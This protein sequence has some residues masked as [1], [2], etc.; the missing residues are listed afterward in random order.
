M[1]FKT[2]NGKEKL[3]KNA[4]KYLINWRTKT[5]SK[6]QDEVKKFLKVGVDTICCKRYGVCGEPFSKDITF[7]ENVSGKTQRWGC[8][9]L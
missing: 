2:L 8:F 7:D 9:V 6:F 5:R 3:L 4:S 1:K